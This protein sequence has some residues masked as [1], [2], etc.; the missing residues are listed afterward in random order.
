MSDSLTR[1]QFLAGSLAAGAA[2]GL[3]GLL[4]AAKE[5]S[6]RTMTDQVPLGSTGIEASYLAF[7]TGTK[8]WQKVSNQ[9]KLGGAAFGRLLRHAYERGI[10]YFD[11][12]DI[13]GTH[14][15]LRAALRNVPRERYVI[16]T[17]I[18]YRTHQDAQ[19]RLDTFRR[20]LGTEYLDIVH[21]HCVDQGTWPVDLRPMMDTLARAKQQGVIRAHGVSCHSLPA[22]QAAAA[23][24][25]VDIAVCRFNHAG[26]KMDGK[27]DDIAALLRGMRAAGKGVTAIKILGEGTIAD[28]RQQSLEYVLRAKAIDAMV[29]GFEKP[30]EIDDIIERGNRILAG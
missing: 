14:Y 15:Y 21:L 24:P 7:G 28:Q 13:Y 6:L 25:W 26:E 3:P 9:T 23:S 18:W 20:E 2:L 10:T 5:P 22:M 17:K 30:E 12:A 16:Q 27:P 11:C 8:G 1:R 19:D 29:I 4:Q